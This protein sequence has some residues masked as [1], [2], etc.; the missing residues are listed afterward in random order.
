M[1]CSVN[2]CGFNG[3]LFFSRMLAD[4]YTLLDCLLRLFMLYDI[5]DVFLRL[6]FEFLPQ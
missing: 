4:G 5:S 1:I 6:A 2:L 3:N